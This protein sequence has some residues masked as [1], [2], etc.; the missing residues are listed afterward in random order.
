MC[1]NV[2]I[3]IIAYND[4]TLLL[5]NPSAMECNLNGSLSNRKDI[6]LQSLNNSRKQKRNKDCIF[7][8][9][10]TMKNMLERK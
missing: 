3:F 1:T 7:C 6:F 5:L 9:V 4:D 2:E 10:F 8:P